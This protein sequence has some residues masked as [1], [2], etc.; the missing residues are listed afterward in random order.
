MS[1]WLLN[2]ASD[3]GE[4]MVGIGADQPHRAYHQNQ[5]H[6][7]HHGVLRNV[8]TPLFGPHS[9]NKLSH[10]T[11]QDRAPLDK[12]P[13]MQGE[14]ALVNYSPVHCHTTLEMSPSSPQ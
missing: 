3:G 7:Q 4:S 10:T 9:P 2:R 11:L 12:A 13:M 14:R 5:D 6:S 1:W 8:L